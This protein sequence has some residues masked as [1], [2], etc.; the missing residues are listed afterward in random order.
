MTTKHWWLATV[1]GTTFLSSPG[2]AL[3]QDLRE[4]TVDEVIVTGQ[5]QAY[6]AGVPLEDVPQSITVISSETLELAGVT[7]LS[8]ALDLSASVARQNNFGGL[9]DS[10]AVRGFAGDENLPSG[11]LVNGFNAGRGFAGPRDAAGIERIEILKGP[12]AAL[13][14]R[15]EPGGSINLVTKRPSFDAAGSVSLRIGEYE[16]YRTELDWTGPVAGDRVAVR[17][18]GFYE[19]AGSFRDTVESERQGFYPSIFARLSERTSLLYELEATTQ[20]VPFDRGVPSIGGRLDALPR[21]RFLGE[22]GD[23]PLQADALGHQLQLQHD[24]SADWSLLVGA[25]FR[26]TDLE[27]FSSEPE[28]AAGRQRLF[29]DG[30]TLSR[31]YRFRDYEGEHTVVRAELSGRF[32]AFGGLHRLLVGA[33]WDAF[34]NSQFFL[35]FRPPALSSNPSEQQGYTIDVFAPVYGRFA[36]PTPP[37]QTNRLDE[38]RAWGIYIQDQIRFGDRFEI[39]IGGRFDDFEQTGT[40][41]AT[42]AVTVFGDSRFSPQIGAVFHLSPETSLYAAYGEGF[43]QNFGADAAGNPFAPEESLSTE[44]GVKVA[45]ADLIGTFALFS[46]E[47]SNVLASDPR[48]A[49]FSLA[50]GEAES[51]GFE[52]DLQGR[53]PGG[54][55]VWASYAWT[56]AEVAR[57]VIDAGTGLVIR[58]GDRLINIPEHSASLQLSKEFQVVGRPLVLGGGV[59]YVSERLGET[60][61]AFELPDHTLVRLF[62]SWQL[63]ESVE[64]SGFLNNAFDETWYANSYSRLWLQ[65][66]APRTAS[67]AVRYRF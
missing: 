3:A 64:V 44:I 65:P 13:F 18:V 14:G 15:G 2:A 29:A 6:R 62:A 4:A 61:T 24:F 28:L 58:P 45:W 59:Q 60:G 66:G 16:L 42:G 7:R 25:G 46:L 23:G 52:A 41:R 12:N 19:E 47:K 54:L 1:L 43:R 30:R 17:I 10:Y 63:S 21:T 50:I 48:N 32:E 5:R 53:L 22:P 11:Y 51:R 55:D 49:G 56:D 8:D 35:R 33:D 36:P 37:V 57:E 20:K 34:D 39:R 38:Q 67:I 26:D 9:W 40:N 31:Q 27:G